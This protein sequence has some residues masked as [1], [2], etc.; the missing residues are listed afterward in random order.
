MCGK[1]LFLFLTKNPALF[2]SSMLFSL[3]VSIYFYLKVRSSVK[4]K[5]IS[6]LGLSLLI[7]IM[8]GTLSSFLGIGGGSINIVVL[9]FF[10]S[11]SPKVTAKR[12]IFIIL[13]AQITGIST[14]FYQGLP[15]GLHS[16]SILLMMLG[17]CLGALIGGKI[18]KKFTDIQMNSFFQDVLVG[19]IALNAFNIG[20]ILGN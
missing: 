1:Y 15:T 8:L 14:T 18:S 9:H 4:T 20:R 17:G 2:Q 10:Y 13:F 3:N 16:P 5:E 7:G 19:V 12:S 11:T 6:S